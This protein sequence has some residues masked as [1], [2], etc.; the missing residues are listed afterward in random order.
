ME[1]CKTNLDIRSYINKKRVILVYGERDH[2]FEAIVNS[3]KYVV[4]YNNPEY[5]MLLDPLNSNAV[6]QRKGMIL[7]GL[8]GLVCYVGKILTYR[9]IKNFVWK[10]SW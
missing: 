10:D 7:V 9:E 5:L 1:Y 8:D 2:D 4:L 6:R 3:C